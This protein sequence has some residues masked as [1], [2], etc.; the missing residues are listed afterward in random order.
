MPDLPRQR[1]RARTTAT[2]RSTRLRLADGPEL[3]LRAHPGP[4][5]E[6]R[7]GRDPVP[8]GEAVVGHPAAVRVAAGHEPGAG[9]RAALDRAARLERGL[10]AR[11]GRDERAVLVPVQVQLRGRALLRR[12]RLRRLAG[13]A[14]D[15][16]AA[17]DRARLPRARRAQAAARRPREH[18][19]RAATG[20]LV[21][22][23]PGRADDLPPRPVRLRRR[24]RGR[25]AGRPTPGSRS[26]A[27]CASS[28]SSRRAGSGRGDFPVNK[29]AR[30]GAGS[31][32]R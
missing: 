12:D 6:R 18:E 11:H 20:E 8:A 27:R 5:H 25:A 22:A 24:G 26:A 28:R 17:G 23:E 13:A 3:A 7:A 9:D 10:R 30:R 21:D 31:S 2:C 15:R 4:A 29:T 19:A 14:R 1:D 32:P 16:Q